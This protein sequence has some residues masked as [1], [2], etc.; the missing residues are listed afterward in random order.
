MDLSD[1]EKETLDLV[2]ATLRCTGPEVLRRGLLMMKL[3]ALEIEAG[4]LADTVLAGDRLTVST[5]LQYIRAIGVHMGAVLAAQEVGVS[6]RTVGYWL[7]NDPV[8]RERVHE[9]N[10]V[11]V[12]GQQRN[13]VNAANA[14]NVLAMQTILNAKHP[15]YGQVRLQILQRVV[16]PL[17]ERVIQRAAHYLRPDDLQRFAADV[18]RY[19]ESVALEAFTG[20]R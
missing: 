10:A 4:G 20:R 6:R 13:L 18:G 8:F 9:A 16:A 1:E 7:E 17:T 12:E 3:Q 5:K 19:G 11:A 2:A 15:D 14:G